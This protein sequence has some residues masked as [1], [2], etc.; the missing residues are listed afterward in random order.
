MKIS[1][2]R[3]EDRL[4]VESFIYNHNL[5]P[6]IFTNFYN[7]GISSKAKT[8]CSL[9][10]IMDQSQKSFLQKLAENRNHRYLYFIVLFCLFFFS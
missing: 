5:L 8:I 2:T 10:L 6:H 4:L 1:D 3:L 9:W 7:D